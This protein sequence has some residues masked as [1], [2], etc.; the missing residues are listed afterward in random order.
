MTTNDKELLKSALQAITA[1]VARLAQGAEADFAFPP[2]CPLP[3]KP[4]QRN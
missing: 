4:Y 1:I 3:Q 2:L